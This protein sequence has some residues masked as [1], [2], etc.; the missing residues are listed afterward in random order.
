MWVKLVASGVLA[1]AVAATF[2]T[3]AHRSLLD[4]P[5][6]RTALDR[7]VPSIPQNAIERGCAAWGESLASCVAEPDTMIFSFDKATRM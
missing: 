2:A 3:G 7:P 5:L 6:K 4:Y 1:V